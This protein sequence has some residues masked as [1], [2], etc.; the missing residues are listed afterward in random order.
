VVVVGLPAGVLAVLLEVVVPVV[1]G[2][3]VPVVVAV[4][5]LVEVPVV[6]VSVPVVVP[7]EVVG[8]GLDLA[9]GCERVVAG[10]VPVATGA[11]PLTEVEDA[12]GRA[13]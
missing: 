12:P 5:V 4:L 9:L 10:A 1:V 3:V 7:V 11:L 13:A 8:A 2:V 6:V